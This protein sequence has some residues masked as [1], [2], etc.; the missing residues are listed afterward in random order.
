M[1]GDGAIWSILIASLLL[2]NFFAIHLYKKGKMPLWRSGLI[3]GI[4]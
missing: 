4:L 1:S 3:I 2:L